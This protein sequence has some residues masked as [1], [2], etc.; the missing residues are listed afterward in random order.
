MSISTFSRAAA[1]ATLLAS[2]ASAAYNAASSQNVAM[3][4]GQGNAQIDLSVVCDDPT[5]DI[6][7]IAFVNGF[8]QKVG[9]YPKTNFGK[10]TA[11]QVLYQFVSR[12]KLDSPYLSVM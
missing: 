1:A 11:Q 5:I 3:Y 7:N 4:W 8:P 9:D 12:S 2:T 6:V 10:N